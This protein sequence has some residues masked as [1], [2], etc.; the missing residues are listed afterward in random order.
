MTKPAFDAD[1]LISMFENASARGSAQLRGAVEQATLT[2]L[3]G[4]ELT[5]KNIRGALDAV[6]KAVSQGA[7]NNTAGIDAAALLDRAVQGMDDA[8][9]KA[10]HAN[11]AALQQFVDRGA[12]LREKQLKKAIDD[13]DKFEDMLF[14]SVKKAASSASPLAAP[15][16]QMLDKL[17]AGGSV[18][19]MT[20]ATTAEDLLAQAHGALR[21]GRAASLRTAQALA[22]SYAAMVSGVLVGMTEAIEANRGKPAAAA[23][24]PAAKAAARKR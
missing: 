19:G 17:K 24:K 13:L 16:S 10:V 1:A 18:A 11:R 12:D 3:Q 14:D 2:A 4:R 15:W 8:L 9:L 7:A 22:D 5:V 20:A 6:T 23:P 21:S